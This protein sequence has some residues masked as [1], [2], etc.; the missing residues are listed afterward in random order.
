MVDS[1]TS[2]HLASYMTKLIRPRPTSITDEGCTRPSKEP[3]VLKKCALRMR[4]WD[5]LVHS[6][7]LQG[8]RRSNHLGNMRNLCIWAGIKQMHWFG[9]DVRPAKRE[10][11][12]PG[13]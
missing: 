6:V 7:P 4:G 10:A 12:E 3:V 9:L 11:W 8:W 5:G 1:S 2:V 13:L